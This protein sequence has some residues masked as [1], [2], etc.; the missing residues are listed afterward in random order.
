MR[1]KSEKFSLQTGFF[2]KDPGESEIP[3]PSS[4]SS[5]SSSTFLFYFLILSE[6]NLDVSF[7]LFMK[8]AGSLWENTVFSIIPIN[9]PCLCL[10][11]VLAY[12]YNTWTQTNFFRFYYLKLHKKF[13]DF[14]TYY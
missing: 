4:F 14:T 5:R 3:V 13:K 10:I 12:F 1:L 7:I 6:A 8:L 11:L 2:Q 9:Y